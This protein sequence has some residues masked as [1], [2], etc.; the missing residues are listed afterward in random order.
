MPHLMSPAGCICCISVSTA[1]TPPRMHVM[2]L[3]KLGSASSFLAQ[4]QLLGTAEAC[5]IRGACSLRMSGG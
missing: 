1:L 4:G 2:A 3:R 5:L